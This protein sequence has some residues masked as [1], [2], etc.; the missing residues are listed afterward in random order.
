MK[1]C[2]RTKTVISAERL[3]ELGK[4]GFKQSV[5]R[6]LARKIEDQGGGQEESSE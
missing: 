4:P 5:H 6:N 1:S 2:N 3:L